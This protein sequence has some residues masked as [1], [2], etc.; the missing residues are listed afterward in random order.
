MPNHPVGPMTG[1]QLGQESRPVNAETGV[2]RQTRVGRSTTANARGSGR[3]T[4]GQQFRPAASS[5][6]SRCPTTDIGVE[7]I[8][9]RRCGTR[10]VLATGVA[11]G[12][13]CREVRQTP[14]CLS[15]ERPR[16]RRADVD[17]Y[18][19]TRTAPTGRCA[20]SGR[21]R[22]RFDRHNRARECVAILPRLSFICCGMP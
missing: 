9:A 12:A 20:L 10:S 14:S 18:P 16:Q 8:S 6:S 1:V 21:Q 5:N 19:G 17:G 22:R 15:I 7:A 3:V 4:A 11:G 13:T 2:F